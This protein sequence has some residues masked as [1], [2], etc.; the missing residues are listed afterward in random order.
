M[1]THYTDIRLHNNC[2]ICMPL[3]YAQAPMLDMNKTGCK[4][5]DLSKVDCKHCLRLFPKRYPWAMTASKRLLLDK[6]LRMCRALKSS[7]PCPAFYGAWDP[8]F[9]GAWD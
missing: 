9:Y 8:A 2:G 3:C 1:K 6:R 5:G 7:V 4:Q